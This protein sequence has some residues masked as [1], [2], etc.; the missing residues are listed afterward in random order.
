MFF[1][2]SIKRGQVVNVE[3]DIPIKWEIIISI[4]VLLAAHFAIF[5]LQSFHF[6]KS[7][8]LFRIRREFRDVVADENVAN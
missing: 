8:Q 4:I 5:H 1:H 3:S 6:E 2:F 7:R